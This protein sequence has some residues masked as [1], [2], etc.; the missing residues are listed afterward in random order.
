MVRVGA[1]YIACVA[2]LKE[3]DVDV[4]D[5]EPVANDEEDNDL[6]NDKLI[7]VGGA[8]KGRG[9]TAA[10]PKAPAKPKNAKS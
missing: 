1:H 7:K 5:E 9:K 10:K 3:D 4:P 8:K 2:E 6:K